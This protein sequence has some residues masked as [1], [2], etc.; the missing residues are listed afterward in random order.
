MSGFTEWRI[1]DRWAGTAWDELDERFPGERSAYLNHPEDSRL[2]S[3]DAHRGGERV[4]VLV[5]EAHAAHDSGDL[6]LVSHQ[7]TIQ[8]GR[9]FLTGRPLRELQSDKPAH[10]RW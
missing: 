4:A 7:D 3:R 10:V 6:V 5:A 8:A 9:L 1:G 2:E